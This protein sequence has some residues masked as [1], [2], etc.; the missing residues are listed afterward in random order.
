MRALIYSFLT[1]LAREWWFNKPCVQGTLYW[2]LLLKAHCL[3]A[4]AFPPF[5]HLLWQHLTARNEIGIIYY[6]GTPLQY[7]C[8]GNPMDGGAWWAAALCAKSHRVG[9]DW[10]DLA[11]AAALLCNKLPNGL[12]TQNYRTT[13]MYYLLSGVYLAEYLCCKVSC[14]FRVKLVIRNMVSSEDSPVR[15]STTKALMWLLSW[16]WC[17]TV[18]VCVLSRFWLCATPGTIVGQ[19]PLSMEFSNQEYW[20]GLPFPS[21]GAL[22]NPGT[23]PV[24]LASPALRVESLLLRHMGGLIS[25]Y[26]CHILCTF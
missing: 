17:P 10:S 7:S 23:E 11:A 9:H 20:S 26:F 5:K 22:P 21:P 19:T 8:L 18:C 1:Y 16:N 14:G 12:E 25:Y 4:Q 2:H 13:N 15:R 3:T 6:N 24:S